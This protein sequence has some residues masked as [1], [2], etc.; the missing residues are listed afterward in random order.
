MR[1]QFWGRKTILL[2]ATIC[3]LQIYNSTHFCFTLTQFNSLLEKCVQT[4]ITLSA[5]RF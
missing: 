4:Q 5:T 2:E 3:S 1:N